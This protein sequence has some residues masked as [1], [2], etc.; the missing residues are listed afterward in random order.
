MLCLK[1]L[2]LIPCQKMKGLILEKLV[3]DGAD[4]DFSLILEFMMVIRFAAFSS[5]MS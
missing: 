2:Y 5:F 1:L 3:S 4:I